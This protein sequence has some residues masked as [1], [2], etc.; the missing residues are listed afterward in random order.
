MIS[1]LN[2]M[3][4]VLLLVRRQEKSFGKEVAAMDSIDVELRNVLIAISVV[5]GT[6]AEKIDKKG[7]KKNERVICSSS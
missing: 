1:V 2:F 5:A 4:A 6:L 7:E 3:V